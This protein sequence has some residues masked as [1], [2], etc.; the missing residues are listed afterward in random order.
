MPLQYIFHV[1][2]RNSILSSA[3]ERY[4][5]ELLKNEQVPESGKQ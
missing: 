3:L 4:N 1:L 5:L 2:T